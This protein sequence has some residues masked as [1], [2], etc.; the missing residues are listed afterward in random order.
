[1]AARIVRGEGATFSDFLA[2]MRRH[3][4]AAVGLGVAATMLALV[5]TVNVWV[6]LEVGGVPGWVL[7]ALALYGNV[8]LAM[9]LVAAW[10]LLVDPLRAELPLRRRLWL[11]ALVNF[12]RPGRMLALTFLIGALIL[13]SVFLFAALLTVSVAYVSL[14]GTRYVLPAADRLEGRATVSQP[15]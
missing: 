12:A 15:D 7:S 14:V 8:G 13:I 1:L 4:G 11:A 6:G 10:P 2:G 3:A 5:F 9:F